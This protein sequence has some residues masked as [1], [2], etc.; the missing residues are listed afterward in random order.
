MEFNL[1]SYSINFVR[2]R[3]LVA[4]ERW[5][6]EEFRLGSDINDGA[7]EGP[8]RPRLVTEPAVPDFVHQ[9]KMALVIPGEMDG[10]LWEFWRQPRK[11]LRIDLP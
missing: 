7:S 2:L 1:F 9:V 8:L 3:Q 11:P 10:S 5:R 4:R 6:V